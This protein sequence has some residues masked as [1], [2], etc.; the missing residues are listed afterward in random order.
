M[1]LAQNRDWDA[2]FA[3][4]TAVISVHGGC[5]NTARDLENCTCPSDPFLTLRLFVSV[6][7]TA[8]SLSLSP[9]LQKRW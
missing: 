6:I 7:L 1:T 2:W 3:A 5:V 8:S 9:L 4:C